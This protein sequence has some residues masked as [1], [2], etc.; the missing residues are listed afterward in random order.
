MIDTYFAGSEMGAE[1]KKDW[2][3][4]ADLANA[5]VYIATQP[6]HVRIDEIRM[7]PMVQDQF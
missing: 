3:K 1:H 6:K 4:A 7:H 5:V 2:L